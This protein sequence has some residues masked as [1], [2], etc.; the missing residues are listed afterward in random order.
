[1]LP[2]GGGQWAATDDVAEVQARQQELLQ[3]KKYKRMPLELAVE[4][5][6]EDAM[7]QLQFERSMLTHNAA[8]NPTVPRPPPS[9]P[10]P[11]PPS[12][13]TASASTVPTPPIRGRRKAA[14]AAPPAAPASSA[15]A[16]AGRLDRLKRVKSGVRTRPGAVTQGQVKRRSPAAPPAAPVAPPSAEAEAGRLA[17]LNRIK[18]G[19]RKRSDAVQEQVKRTQMLGMT[20]SAE[21]GQSTSTRV[22]RRHVFFTTF[23]DEQAREACGYYQLGFDWWALQR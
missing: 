11:P 7:R 15:E 9:I 13:A 14:A 10:R 3:E 2:G 22:N 21:L 6:T 20:V 5:A 8:A 4:E 16:E 1:L 23:S 18:R 17:R 19:V 12:P